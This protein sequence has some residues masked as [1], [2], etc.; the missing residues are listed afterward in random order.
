MSAG[1]LGSGQEHSIC[2]K[3]D[4]LDICHLAETHAG[5]PAGTEGRDRRQMAYIAVRVSRVTLISPATE[6]P[7]LLP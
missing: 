3:A 2:E 4:E 1:V 5:L 7:S 6:L